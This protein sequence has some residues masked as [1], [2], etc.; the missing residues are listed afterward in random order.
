MHGKVKSFDLTWLLD[1]D[2]LDWKLHKVY[3]YMV[4]NIPGMTFCAFAEKR[5]D[6]HCLTHTNF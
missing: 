4:N 1:T 5:D 3:A 6:V 2:N